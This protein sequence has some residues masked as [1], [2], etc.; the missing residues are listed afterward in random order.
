VTIAYWCIAAA[1]ALIY[2]CT[3]LAK[4]GGRMPLGANHTPRDWLDRLQGW[5]KRAHWAQ[6]NGFEAFPIFAAAVL[7]AQTSHATQTRIDT[8]AEW[9]IAFRVLYIVMYLA[10]IALLRTLCWTGGIACCAWLFVLAA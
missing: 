3:G 5:P 10:D 8:L 7:V 4:G 1:A 6:Q 2:L 9:F